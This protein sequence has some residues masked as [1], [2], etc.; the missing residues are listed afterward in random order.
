MDEE[1]VAD[2]ASC[3]TFPLINSMEK[4]IPAGKWCSCGSL[5]VRVGVH[6][7]E[8]LPGNKVQLVLLLPGLLSMLRLII[9]FV[10]GLSRWKLKGNSLDFSLAHISMFFIGYKILVAMAWMSVTLLSAVPFHYWP[11]KYT[12]R[13]GIISFSADANLNIFMIV[14]CNQ[15]LTYPANPWIL[16]YPKPAHVVIATVLSGCFMMISFALVFWGE[17][18][19]ATLISWAYGLG[20]TLVLLR[21]LLQTGQMVKLMPKEG[22]LSASLVKMNIFFTRLIFLWA[23]YFVLLMSLY[24]LR[25]VAS[26]KSV[27]VLYMFPVLIS[28]LFVGDNY[29]VE[30]IFDFLYPRMRYDQVIEAVRKMK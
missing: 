6:C 11:V 25:A 26:H 27:Y 16:D 7:T 9:K 20:S 2:Y 5:T 8:T 23:F 19:V 18:V 13:L 1:G 24:V 4:Y 15:V 29:Y 10:L 17:T 30:S 14:L 3:E 12:T 22:N 21:K 28:L